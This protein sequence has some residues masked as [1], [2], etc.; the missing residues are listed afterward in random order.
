MMTK[1]IKLLYG[2]VFISIVLGGGGVKAQENTLG[3]AKIQE[4]KVILTASK[5][6]ILPN[7]LLEERGKSKGVI[8]SSDGRL[9]KLFVEDFDSGERTLID[10]FS[11]HG[12]NPAIR[13]S[14]G[15]RYVCYNVFGADRS[16]SFKIYDLET[17]E[18]IHIKRADGNAGGPDVNSQTGKILYQIERPGEMA[19]V[20]LTDKN[21]NNHQFIAEGRGARWSPNGK[22]FYLLHDL[23]KE[24]IKKITEALVKARSG[25]LSREKSE[26]KQNS[27]KVKTQSVQRPPRRIEFFNAEGESQFEIAQFVEPAHIVWSP[28]SDKIVL[29]DW[30]AGKIFLIS[31]LASTDSLQLNSVEEILSDTPQ[32]EYFIH[33]A[34]SPD[35]S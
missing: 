25:R 31:F 5:D 2:M 30:R 22:W 16:V 19:K 6:R 27:P 17:G 35:G 33:P 15:G 28:Q 26:R 24:T 11:T 21:G 34:W 7:L 32:R 4:A 12:K 8:R 23:D 3:M 20:Y 1:N 18:L 29:R 14:G 9:N 13:L 10:E